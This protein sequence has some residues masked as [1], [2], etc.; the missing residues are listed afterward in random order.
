MN[1][2]SLIIVGASARAAA[3]SALRAGYRPWCIDLFADRDLQAIAAVRA[4]HDYPHAIPAM[5]DD[6]PPAPVLLT[7]AMELYPETLAAMA[8][9]R[10]L[11]HASIE[12]IAAARNPRTL[13]GIVPRG[14]LRT[15]A[16]S[17]TERNGYL[18]KRAVVGSHYWQQSIAGTPIGAVYRG[19]QWLGAS[20]QL[21]A[22]P[23]LGADGLR[24]AGSIGPLF[25]DES[26]HAALVTLGEQLTI[27]GGLRGLY[28]VDLMIDEHGDLWPVE[29][30]PRYTASIEVL[31]RAGRFAALK[32]SAWPRP[33]SGVCGKA[34]VYARHTGAA[35]DLYELFAPDEVADV[36]AE[37][38][39]IAVGEPICT[40]FAEA[41]DI[42]ACRAQ[43]HKMAR[44]LY[45]RMAWR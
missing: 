22:D 45:T 41:A 15:C 12:A 43:L 6:A 13:A 20:V 26:Q 34:I 37:G 24:Y 18:H 4:C 17:V 8:R 19:K 28:G 5:L 42:A 36:P 11:L 35:P 31:E 7:G 1:D 10:P 25:L 32:D 16:V 29:I 39:A 3:Q 33:R 44:R 14:R 21:I 9:R 27:H 38:R 40:A 23:L 2:P 30:N